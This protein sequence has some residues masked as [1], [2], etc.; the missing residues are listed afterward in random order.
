MDCTVWLRRKRNQVPWIHAGGIQAF[1]MNV[2]AKRNVADPETIHNAIGFIATKR[3]AAVR[4][5]FTNLAPALLGFFLN[6][7]LEKITLKVFRHFFKSAYPLGLLFAQLQ[8]CPAHTLANNSK[9]FT[10]WTFIAER[11]APYRLTTPKTNSL[12]SASEK[13]N[14]SRRS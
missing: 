1:V 14:D 7:K 5:I 2:E 4:A 6:N 8:R 12:A 3:R 11:S 9:M 13:T 10:M